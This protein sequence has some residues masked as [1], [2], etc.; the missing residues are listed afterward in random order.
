[1]QDIAKAFAW[2]LKLYLS[3]VQKNNKIECELDLPIQHFLKN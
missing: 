1:M 2:R 3:L